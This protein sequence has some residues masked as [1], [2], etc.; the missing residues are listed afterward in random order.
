MNYPPVNLS[1]LAGYLIE[2]GF[3]NTKIIDL[4]FEIKNKFDV[5]N[6]VN[7]GF[8]ILFKKKPDVICITCNALQFPFVCE[9]SSLIK[10]KTQIPVVVGGVMPSLSLELV[11][12][13]S[14][15]DFVVRGEGEQ[16]L[17]ELLQNI[18]NNRNIK[19]IDG[20]SYYEQNGSVV[21]N[22]D[23]AFIDID[24]LPKP[25]FKLIKKSLKNSKTV[26]LT[27]SRGC[28]YKCKF[29]SGNDIWKF[30]RRKNPDKIIEQLKILK[31]KYGIK[32][33]IFG[34]DCLTL[35]KNWIKELCS[36]IKPLKMKWGCLA[37]IDSIDKDILKI[38]K[39]AGCCHIYHGIE[40]GSFKVRKELDKKMN[41]SNDSIIKTVKT[42]INLG[43]KVTC[44]FMSG[45]PFE[46]KYD[47]VKTFE[48]AK[49]IKKTRGRIQLWLLTPYPGLKI[50]QEYKKRLIKID[51][52]SANLQ[53]DVFDKGQMFLYS[54]F[55]DK[56]VKYNPDNFIFLPKGMTADEF[57]KLFNNIRKHL[58]LQKNKKYLTG[59][60]IFVLKNRQ[61]V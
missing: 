56:Y 46:T 49:Q 26:W 38:M 2:K 48:L 50:L 28:A 37:R 35:N 58:N 32:E 30:Q 8:N 17:V 34:D 44:S 21:H 20:I 23:R 54:S 15:A 14:K 41:N 52:Q 42:E 24:C 40:S 39:E 11:L 31:I 53:T 51:R 10:T 33:F 25:E 61:T 16:T 9:L 12:N 45:I 22:K 5:A 47:I 13:L 19:Q 1:E 55:I 18:K 60:E 29:C 36:K 3:K 27:G 7:I 57:M 59:R 6:I 43:F 4:N